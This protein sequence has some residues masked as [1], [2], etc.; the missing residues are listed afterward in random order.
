MKGFK[1]DY[2]ALAVELLEKMHH[3]H[4]AKPQ[5]DIDE[6]M[7]GE[8]LMLDYLAHH[9][10][11]ALPGEISNQMNVSSARIAQMLNNLEK[12]GWIIREIN[13]DDRRKIL[14]NLTSAG[15]TEARERMQ[16]IVKLA[17]KMLTRL[18][19]DDAREYVRIMGRL[20]DM[21]E[22]ESACCN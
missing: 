13:P 1:L 20:I 22:E 15:R 16:K 3:L 8:T 2:S 19:E 11:E 6:A 7:Q 9:G 12:K 17:T 18:G 4:G 14:V 21:I 5:K 10:G